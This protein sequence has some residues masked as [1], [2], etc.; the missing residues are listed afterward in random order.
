MILTY[1]YRLSPTKGQRADLDDILEAQRELYNAALQER[2]DAYR[3][4]GIARTYIDQT[5]GLTEWRK[6]DPEAR[7]VPV[8]MQRATLHRVD[9]AFKGFFRRV[10]RARKPG[11]PR[12]RGRSSFDSFGFRENSG[13]EVQGNRMRF[14]GLRGTLRIH[15]HRPLPDGSRIRCCHLRRSIHGWHV[16]FV[17]DFPEAQTLSVGPRR[18]VGVD[19]G[20]TTL[21]VLSDGTVIPRLRAD[22]DGQPRLRVLQRAVSRKA[23]GSRRRRLASRAVASFRAAIKR[24]RLNH[25]HCASAKLV[26]EY[27]VI[28]IEDIPIMGLASGPLAKNVRDASWGRFFT[29]LRY[30]AERAGKRIVAVDAQGTSQECTA[31]RVQVT[32]TLGERWHECPNCGLSIDRDLNAAINILYRAGVGPGPLNVAGCGM[33]AGE[34]IVRWLRDRTERRTIETL[35]SY[36]ADS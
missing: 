21:A 32:K 12:F 22:S 33:R 28:A 9:R 6:S 17:V 4:A 31:C 24:R 23:P 13:Y 27:D 18:V 8:S 5:R 15:L 20:L 36:C 34:N 25:L 10:S 2:I 19:V 3:K 11:F 30:K 7:S 1:R 16:C 14:K 26:G 35:P 29:M